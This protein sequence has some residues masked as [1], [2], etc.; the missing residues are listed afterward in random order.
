MRT[1]PKGATCSHAR[2]RY[3]ACGECARAGRPKCA[4]LCPDCG[5]YWMIYEGVFG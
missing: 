5:F 2:M 3:V 4:V 1:V